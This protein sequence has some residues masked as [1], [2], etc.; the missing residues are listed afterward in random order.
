MRSRFSALLV[1]CLALFSQP[2]LA[3]KIEQRELLALSARTTPAT[4]VIIGE[5][6]GWCY[7]H[8]N[9]TEVTDTPGLTVNSQIYLSVADTWLTIGSATEFTPTGAEDLLLIFG[10]SAGFSDADDL[11]EHVT[12]APLGKFNRIQVGTA[13]TDEAIYSVETICG[14]GT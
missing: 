13:D 12:R 3:D 11:D 4:A 8:V 9:V 1:L 14:Q 2:A 5:A 6:W 10:L 7:V